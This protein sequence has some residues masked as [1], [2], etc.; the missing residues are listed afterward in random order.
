VDPVSILVVLMA[1]WGIMRR[2]PGIVGQA[3][4]EFQASRHGDTTPAAKAR[5]DALIDA[6]V[7]PASGGPMRQFFGNAWRDY[8]H[9]KDQ[10][11]QQERAD[12]AVDQERSWWRR[13][14]DD[15]IDRQ[16]AKYRGTPAADDPPAE[17]G[18]AHEDEPPVIHEPETDP[19]GGQPAP[20]GQNPAGSWTP[21]AEGA[22]RP[23]IRVHATVGEPANQPSR[24]ATAVLD[25]PETQQQIE[26]KPDMSSAVAN[27]GTAVTGVV[28]GAA[29]ARS[30]QRALAAATAEY[31]AAV[32]AARQRIH[33]LGEQ[34]ISTVQMAGR[35]TVV[36]AT[37]QAAE[38]IAAAQAG[39]NACSAEVIPLMGIV[40]REFDKRNS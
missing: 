34:T 3:A 11:R 25:P 26:G 21:P 20:D 15:A 13:R 14:L 16:S 2:M 1:A 7:D 17:A 5:R 30:I 24:T 19:V 4:A 33:S 22:E 29:E 18:D 38:A 8:W 10:Q 31:A 32:A 12:G 35:S 23:P 28:S 9:D 37:A 6:G 39:V 40:A 27:R 36:A